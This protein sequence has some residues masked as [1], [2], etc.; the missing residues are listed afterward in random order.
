MPID[1]LVSQISL[2][3]RILLIGAVVFLAAW[4]TVLRPKAA[5]CRR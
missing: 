3:V 5:A 2:P 4:F 1:W